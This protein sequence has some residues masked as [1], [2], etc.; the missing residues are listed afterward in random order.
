MTCRICYRQFETTRQKHPFFWFACKPCVKSARSKSDWHR[1]RKKG[2][3]GFSATDWLVCLLENEFRCFWCKEQK[4]HLTLDHDVSLNF[5]GKNIDSN[6]KPLC[7][8]CHNYKSKKEN[9]LIGF[10]K[11]QKFQTL[12][13][14]ANE[15]CNIIERFNSGGI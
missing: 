15:A 8:V 13:E 7:E 5:G 12:E 10:L 3:G 6:L 2:R 14:A 1:K 9:Q 11:K 4:P